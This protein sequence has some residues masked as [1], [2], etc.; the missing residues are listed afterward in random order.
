MSRLWSQWPQENLSVIPEPVIW[1]QG[2]KWRRQGEEKFW[3]ERRWPCVGFLP[4]LPELT[5]KKLSF[6]TTPGAESEIT[7]DRDLNSILGGGIP[8]SIGGVEATAAVALLM[9]IRIKIRELEFEPFWQGYGQNCSETSLVVS[10]WDKPIRS[11][12]KT[13]VLMR[14]H[15]VL[16]SPLRLFPSFRERNTL[17]FEYARHEMDTLHKTAF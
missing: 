9:G 6:I 10:I 7:Y 12:C 4:R 3:S 1:N 2:K 16:C 15:S 11:I 17:L 13:E 8:L 5:S 14:M